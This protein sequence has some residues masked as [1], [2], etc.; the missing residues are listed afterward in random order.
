M[1][2][3]KS[4]PE[5]GPR[6]ATAGYPG[7][8]PETQSGEAPPAETGLFVP[9]AESVP[10]ECEMMAVEVQ[11]IIRSFHSSVASP[12]ATIGLELELL[13]LDS[14]TSPATGAEL[15]RITGSLDA[16]IAVIRDANRKL[17]I[18]EKKI[19]A[20]GDSAS[21]NDGESRSEASTARAGARASRRRGAV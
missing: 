16:V 11:G 4:L 10:L 18:M 19:R 1:P 5:P 21:G 13:R 12:L 15:A 17:R 14:Q 8:A 2:K 3:L 9:T 7:S 20:H 6:T